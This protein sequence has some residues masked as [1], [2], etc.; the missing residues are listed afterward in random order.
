[1]T[2]FVQGEARGQAALLPECLDDW[3][4]ENNPCPPDEPIQSHLRGGK[5]ARLDVFDGLV[6]AHR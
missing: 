2:R 6:C 3:I 4:D 5:Q 1:M